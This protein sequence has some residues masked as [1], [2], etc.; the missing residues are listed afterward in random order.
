[1]TQD[2]AGRLC[3]AKGRKAGQMAEL[4]L[5]EQIARR[6]ERIYRAV[7]PIAV[8]GIVVLGGYLLWPFLSRL[9]W[10][11]LSRPDV[12]AIIVVVMAVAIINLS[13]QAARRPPSPNSRFLKKL[14][15]EP[16]T[17]EHESPNEPPIVAG[18]GLHARCR[19][20]ERHFFADFAEFADI[21]NRWFAA[22]SPWRLKQLPDDDV[23]LNVDFSSGPIFGRCY[24]IFHN[25][26]ELGRL[27]IQPQLPTYDTATPEVITE[28]ELHSVRLLSYDTI[29]DFLSVIAMYV[30]DSNPKDG[31]SYTNPNEAIVG[32]LTKALWETQ[33]ITE[34]ADWG[35][36]SLRFNGLA[37]RL[38]FDHREH[39]REALQ[40]K[41]GHR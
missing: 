23:R 14:F 3:L 24:A 34:F 35:E 5:V 18:D 21:V 41:R 13:R 16:I 36:L 20:M 27:E 17:P 25:Q 33:R 19:D 37:T 2:K 29:A 8:W 31:K 4:S 39:H 7:M 32:A 11:Y 6:A 28:I 12:L 22:Y 30:C 38:Y 15:S 1:M 9:V 10:P 26:V 40:E